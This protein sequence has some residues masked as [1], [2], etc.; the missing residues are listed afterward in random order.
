MKDSADHI[1]AEGHEGKF[2]EFEVLAGE[3]NT[4]DGDK[5]YKGKHQVYEGCVEATAKQPDDIAKEWKAACATLFGHYLFAERPKHYSCEF[6]ALQAPG[7]AHYGNAQYEAANNVA[8]GRQEA[9][10]DE[11]DEVSY[12]IHSHGR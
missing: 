9:A 4:D 6:E 2:H 7:Y 8:D 10:E 1:A 3:G 12:Q 11:P 5:E